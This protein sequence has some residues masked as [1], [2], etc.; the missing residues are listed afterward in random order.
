MNGDCV[1][2]KRLDRRNHLLVDLTG[3][4]HN[5][6]KA[7]FLVVI[8]NHQIV[9]VA[10]I[11][12]VL[13]KDLCVPAFFIAGEYFLRRLC[14]IALK[15]IYTEVFFVF[16]Q[17]LLRIP[18]LSKLNAMLVVV[19]AFFVFLNVTE[20]I[21]AFGGTDPP[22]HTFNLKSEI[23]SLKNYKASKANCAFS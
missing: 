1:V 19:A 5:E 2:T 6:R 8:L 17:L 9:E 13:V 15:D 18:D 14:Q 4:E 7:L 20:H 11:F 16:L 21:D 22:G 12:Q 10:D 23:W 3:N